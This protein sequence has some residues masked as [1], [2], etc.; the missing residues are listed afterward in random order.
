[1]AKKYYVVWQ[2]RDTGIFT[3]WNA[4]K[5]QVDKFAGA[6]YKSFKTLAEAETAFHGD[7]I[8]P[9]K[10]TA[11]DDKSLNTALTKKKT[12]AQGVKR[13]APIKSQQCR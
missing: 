5:K 11:N 7:G 2:G 4:C 6:Q 9:I 3:D 10:G 1:M 8:M 13:I 12:T